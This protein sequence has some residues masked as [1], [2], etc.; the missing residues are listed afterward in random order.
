MRKTHGRR[1]CPVDRSRV[2]GTLEEV[3]LCFL[4]GQ[5]RASRPPRGAAGS[6]PAHVPLHRLVAVPVAELLDCRSCKIRWTRQTR[7][8]ASRGSRPRYV[9]AAERGGA[10][11][12]GTLWPDLIRSRRSL[13]PHLDP[14]TPAGAPPTR[15]PRLR[16][17]PSRGT[18]W[19]DLDRPSART[20]TP[21]RAGRP[22]PARSAGNVQ[23]RARS[24]ITCC[25]F[26]IFRWFAR[27]SSVGQAHEHARQAP[28]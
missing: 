5:A 20:A 8:R 13:W 17:P 10:T 3:H 4:A 24:A 23:P 12:R 25:L 19:P 26:V 2:G 21:S 28:T 18:L 7:A 9:A 6:M 1:H 14:Q 15:R 27:A 22:S 11:S 16:R